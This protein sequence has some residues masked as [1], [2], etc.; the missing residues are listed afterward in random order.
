[1]Y[2]PYITATLA[3][4]ISGYRADLAAKFRLTRDYLNGLAWL[5]QK[6]IIHR[7]IKPLNLGILNFATFQGVILDLDEAIIGPASWDHSRGTVN[8]LAP[9]VLNLKDWDEKVVKDPKVC[10][11]PYDSKIDVF[12][13]G[14]SIHGLLHDQDFS[15]QR[16]ADE[17][18]PLPERQFLTSGIFNN[19]WTHLRTEIQDVQSLETLFRFLVMI[20]G[21]MTAY[22]PAQ[23]SDARYVFALI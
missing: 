18:N 4:L 13:L 16:F 8:F 20:V 6:E 2:T 12:A 22:Y 7:D 17:K 3:E 11:P 1:M 21:R 15:W 23:R 19:Y 9:E 14:L 5:E 10:P